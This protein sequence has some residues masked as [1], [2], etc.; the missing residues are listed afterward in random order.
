MKSQSVFLVVLFII[1]Q[2]TSKITIYAKLF[3]L[4]IRKERMGYLI[5]SLHVIMTMN[6][7]DDEKIENE[8]CDDDIDDDDIWD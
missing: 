2:Y 7:D 5:L 3:Y 1:K 6:D 4:F 8:S